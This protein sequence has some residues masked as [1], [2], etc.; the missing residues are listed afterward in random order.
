MLPGGHKGWAVQDSS[1]C[2]VGPG[3]TPMTLCHIFG[4][5]V[6]TTHTTAQKLELPLPIASHPHLHLCPGTPPGLIQR[7]QSESELSAHHCQVLLLEGDSS[8]PGGTEQRPQRWGRG[9]H[10]CTV[11]Q[12]AACSIDVPRRQHPQL[13]GQGSHLEPWPASCVPQSG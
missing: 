2:S 9:H 1:C 5:W 11:V 3:H 7:Q 12:G 4:H 10:S 13:P 8:S 6:K